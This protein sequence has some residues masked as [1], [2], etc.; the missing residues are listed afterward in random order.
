MAQPHEVL[1][2]AANADEATINAAFRKAAK[3]FHPDLNNGDPAGVQR[4][5]RLI[6]ARDFL[7]GR[8]WRSFNRQ[9]VRYLLPALRRTRIGKSVILSFVL[10]GV[11]ALLLL[12]AFVSSSL[13]DLALVRHSS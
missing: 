6:A 13:S 1:G 11:C 4:L 8:K 9:N 12:P 10:T 7:T 2:V 3:R 5:R